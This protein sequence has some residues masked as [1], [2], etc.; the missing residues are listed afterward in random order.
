MNRAAASILTIVLS[1]CAGAA[2]RLATYDEPR[3]ERPVYWRSA[4]GTLTTWHQE[5]WEECWRQLSSER[6]N[7]GE[8]RLRALTRERGLESFDETIA[9]GATLEN[10]VGSLTSLRLVNLAGEGEAIAGEIALTDSLRDEQT[11]HV[12]HFV[13][14][15]DSLADSLRAEMDSVRAA[16]NYVEFSGR[17]VNVGM[18]RLSPTLKPRRRN[19]LELLVEVMLV[20]FHGRDDSSTPPTS[21][22]TEPENVTAEALFHAPSDPYAV[23]LNVELTRIRNFTPPEVAFRLA[24]QA[25]LAL[26]ADLDSMVH[27]IQ[28]DFDPRAPVA[29]L[30]DSSLAARAL[31]KYNHEDPAYPHP[32]CSACLAR[33]ERLGL[34]SPDSLLYLAGDLQWLLA[35]PP[36]SLGGIEMGPGWE[37]RFE[38]ADSKECEHYVRMFDAAAERLRA[39]YRD[40]VEFLACPR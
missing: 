28:P 5:G 10:W 11:P 39:R 19:P 38:T 17:V 22:G 20:H 18:F 35:H 4:S 9:P 21:S 14:P 13:A 30:E 31:R 6:A 24:A 27:A 32:L 16:P 1:C 15:T 29:V 12:V 3:E 25:R 36:T 40:Y 37:P 33:A 23:I 2:L 8:N 26:P 34:A 7:A